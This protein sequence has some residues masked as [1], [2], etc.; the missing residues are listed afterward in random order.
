M[1]LTNCTY[2]QFWGP[3]LTLAD[4]NVTVSN[5]IEPFLST[6]LSHAR[7]PSAYPASRARAL[8]PT[9]LEWSWVSPAADA[10]VQAAIIAAES[11]LQRTVS[12]VDVADPDVVKYGNYAWTPDTRVEDIFGKS[13]PR[14]RALKRRYDPT[15][16]MELTGGWKV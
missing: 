10:E 7:T 12:G 4:P 6:I 13:L 8:L 3:R 11:Q 9:I 14:L 1:S 15:G 2:A 5:V 16:V